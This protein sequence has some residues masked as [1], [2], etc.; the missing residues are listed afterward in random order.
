MRYILS[1][2]FVLVSF[3]GWS[4][5]SP[6][7]LSEPHHHL[8]GIKNCTQ[9]HVLGDRVTNEKCLDCHTQINDRITA[10]KG[11][12]ASD[13]VKGKR[14]VECHNEHHG[15]KYDLTGLEKEKFNHDLTGYILEGEHKNL[16]CAECH[17]SEH[18]QDEEL[19]KLDH[20][21][22]GLNTNCVS[23]H[24]DFHQGTLSDNCLSCHNYKAFRPAPKFNHDE[25]DFKLLGKHN[26]LDCIECHT[27][28]MLNGDEFQHFANVD[29]ANCTSCHKDE[30]DGRLGQNC[31]KCHNHNSFHEVKQLET[32]DHNLTA[33]PLEGMHQQV[34]CKE[35]HKS[36][37][38][39]PLKHDRCSACHDDEHDGQFT[40]KNPESDCA[41]CHSVKSFDFTLF[42]IERH[43][44]TSFKLEGAHMAT[45]CFAC[46]HEQGS[47]QFTNKQTNCVACHENEHENKM[48]EKFTNENGC[49]N[50]HN[51]NTW[52]TIKFDHSQTDFKLE[53]VHATVSCNECHYRLN[54]ENKVEQKF[55]TTS[56]SC[57]AC[58]DDEHQGQFSKY[59]EDGCLKCHGFNDW[60]ASK[61][62]HQNTGFPLDGAHESLDCFECHAE[63]KE[64]HKIYTNYTYE[65]FQCA[66]CH[67]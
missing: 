13:D 5:I 66:V 1:F 49:A 15:R 58:H 63:L 36:N 60:K 51:V 20:T 22:Q 54:S 25:T 44:E 46:H 61:F 64:N 6:G 2:I 45:P 17:K 10:D 37:Y 67:K 19:K 42:T 32:F 11:Y 52:S 43:N 21:Y 34:D 26:T 23:C 39:D 7:D 4:Q 56:Q 38:T 3:L 65:D 55:H 30:H 48:S 9:C 27:K 40:D 59:G 24:N 28:D 57:L 53:G 41:E 14:C 16:D 18:I 62:N 31:L 50:C 8:E 12:H 47:W 29:H 35:C 33:Y